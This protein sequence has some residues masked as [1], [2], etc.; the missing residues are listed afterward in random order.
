[1]KKK[2]SWGSLTMGV[3]AASFVVLAAGSVTNEDPNDPKDP[4]KEQTAGEVLG[5]P[6]DE[7]ATE[8]PVV[9]NQNVNVA[10][11]HITVETDKG[12]DYLSIYLTGVWN[13]DDAE[14]LNLLGTGFNGQN[15]WIT[16]DDQ[17]KGVDVYN[18]SDD[19]S[20]T[21]IADVVFLVDNSGSMGEEAEA[22]AQSIINW[23][24]LL[25]ASGLDLNVGC[26]G[27]GDSYDA[28][29]GAI[30]MCKPDEMD[31][32]MQ[33]NG[34]GVWRTHSF[35][36]EDA[37]NLRTLARNGYQNGSYNECG[38]VALHFAHDNFN[39]RS[40][41][42]RIY[43]NFTDEPNQPNG[44]ED[45]SVEYL[46][47]ENGNWNTNDGTIHT[48]YSDYKYDYDSYL[49]KESPWKMSEY[50]GGTTLFTDRYFTD[51]T[52]ENIPV[53][54]AMQN[55]YILRITN[56]SAYFDGKEHKITITIYD[57]DGKIQAE[58]TIYFIFGEK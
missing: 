20:K 12:H 13:Q 30:N 54:G 22:V 47:P 24:A 44:I 53:T 31:T 34:S 50:T 5:I 8:A 52:L 29:D 10:N 33:N 3:V 56:I 55:S 26:V 4:S 40:G 6:E 23:S 2:F 43:V 11:P 14:W 28:I 25:S 17:P 7:E 42:N 39:F 36:G 37:D 1:M 48:V 35:G 57:K 38:M 9:D 19:N 32:W 49:W 41:S 45:W 58:K 18:N 46:N 27:Y 51:F 16:V 21:L 15:V